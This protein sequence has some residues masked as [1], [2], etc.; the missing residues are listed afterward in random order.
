[1]SSISSVKLNT[2][3]VTNFTIIVIILLLLGGNLKDW[4]ARLDSLQWYDP[5]MNVTWMCQ[6]ASALAYL[7][8][9]NT[10][11]RDLKL[12]NVLLTIN[13][14][15]KL[16]D[17]GLARKYIAFEQNYAGLVKQYM[18]TGAGTPYCMAPEVFA[19]HYTEKSDVFSLGILFFAIVERCSVQL[20]DGE[21][22]YGAFV[23]DVQ[24]PHDPVALGIAMA[25][26]YPP[27]VLPF[28]RATP[29]LR[30][31]IL[32]ALSR[33]Y[34]QRITAVDLLIRLPPF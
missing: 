10:V 3:M 30:G 20:P 7:H 4:L 15:I 8:L 23:R 2:L 9:H 33:D 25:S 27:I 32:D 18:Q 1:M 11:H 31:L 12:E 24:P 17:F 26:S 19:G 28:T 5:L 14:N 13:G 16:A 21:R 34:H 29:Y 6:I 22:L